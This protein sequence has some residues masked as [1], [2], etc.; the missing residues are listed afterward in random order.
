MNIDQ[1]GKLFH[2]TYQMYLNQCDMIQQLKSMFRF[3]SFL[4]NQIHWIVGGSKHSHK[5]A[6][7]IQKADR[8]QTS[9]KPFPIPCNKL[10]TERSA[11]SATGHSTYSIAVA[12]P[13]TDI[14]GKSKLFQLL[15]SEDTQTSFFLFYVWILL[16][17][18][19]IYS[20][21][22]SLNICLSFCR[23]GLQIEGNQMRLFI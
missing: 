17:S 21:F 3:S 23:G 5:Q 13:F 8:M 12:W 19:F 10:Q 14:T 6:Y 22:F 15:R 18:L 7:V 16:F 4:V 1:R 9:T 2:Y 20:I 11:Q